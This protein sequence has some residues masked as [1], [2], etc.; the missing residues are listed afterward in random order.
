MLTDIGVPY[1]AKYGVG[2]GMQ[3]NVRIRMTFQSMR[4]GHF[5][6]A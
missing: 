4:V 2:Q 1:G 6:S 3:A 5:Y